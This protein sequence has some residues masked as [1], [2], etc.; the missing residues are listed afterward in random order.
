MLGW[1]ILETLFYYD[2]QGICN[3]QCT[4]CTG[5]SVGLRRVMQE[6]IQ[7]YEDFYDILRDDTE[8]CF[9]NNINAITTITL[10]PN[11]VFTGNLLGMLPG[12]SQGLFHNFQAHCSGKW[13]I[14]R[15][16]V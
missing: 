13:S 12:N 1:D 7:I 11:I 6:H 16:N 9:F 2:F 15:I 10:N 4:I 8:G 5:I 3:E 14:Q